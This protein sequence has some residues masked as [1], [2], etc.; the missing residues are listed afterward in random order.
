VIHGADDPMLPLGHGQALASRIPG[1]SL[2][3]L[4]RT[5]HELPP[6]VWDLVVPAILAHTAGKR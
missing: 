6:A 4:E 3:T 2:L 1:A 5:G